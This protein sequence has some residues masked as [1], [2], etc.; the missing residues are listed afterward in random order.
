MKRSRTYMGG[1]VVGGATKVRVA[2]GGI[3]VPTG[4]IDVPAGCV[5]APTVGN[6]S[7]FGEE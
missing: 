5:D 1:N 3:N 2:S 7:H 6:R 4:G